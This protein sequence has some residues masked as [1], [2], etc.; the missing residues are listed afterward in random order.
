MRLTIKRNKK[1]FTLLEIIIVVII[2]G[3]LASLALPRLFNTV[4]F[5]RSTEAMSNIGAL[6]Q[7]IERCQLRNSGYVGCNAYGVGGITDV[8]NPNGEPNAHF[9]YAIT[10]QAGAG[11]TI[12]ATRIALDGGNAGD[13]ITV[14]INTAAGTL[15]KVGTA[16]FVNL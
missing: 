9:T 10:L 12:Q 2:V 4:E 14:T 1:G 5:S 3:V 16:A 8:P 11:Y 15:T 13:T 6:R 7:A